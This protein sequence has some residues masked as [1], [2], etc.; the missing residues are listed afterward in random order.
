MNAAAHENVATAES[1]PPR[2]STTMKVDPVT[3][4]QESIDGLSLAMFEALRKLRDAVAPESGSL[5]IV[6]A[7][8]EEDSTHRPA[9]TSS[10]TADV[11]EVWALYRQGDAEMVQKIQAASAQCQLPAT[12]TR[13]E[14]FVRVHAYME[15]Q[16][17]K[18]MVQTLADSIL[19]KSDSINAQVSTQI[20]GMNR[21]ASQQRERIAALIQEHNAVAAELQSLYDAARSRRDQCRQFVLDNTCEAL[22]IGSFDEGDTSED[23]FVQ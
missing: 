3:A 22:G 1:I 18:N 23:D 4:L 12:L 21:T 5:G 20:P 19:E 8:P 16:K 2:P 15:L 7:N 14:E 10:T 13:R 17:D 6:M 9:A 11:D